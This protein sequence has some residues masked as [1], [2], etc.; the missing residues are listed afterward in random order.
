M[1]K[2]CFFII[3]VL[4]ANKMVGMNGIEYLQNHR[5]FDVVSVTP[6]NLSLKL[7]S[8]NLYI[9]N[10]D[11]KRKYQNPKA[12]PF[13]PF[14]RRSS[15]F[16]KNNELLVLTPDQVTTFSTRRHSLLYFTPVL[17]KTQEKGFQIRMEVHY[18]ETTTTTMY[19]ALSDTPKE[20]D[21]DDVE[22]IWKNG[23]L[24]TLEECQAIA[25]Q[26]KEE[27][28]AKKKF[29]ARF[30]KAVEEQYE[31]K[32]DRQAFEDKLNAMGS[33]EAILAYLDELE[34]QQHEPPMPNVLPPPC[35]T[36][37]RAWLWWLTLPVVA[38][39]WFVVYLGKKRK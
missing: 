34:S 18:L 1:K 10:D 5:W 6:T 19:F 26:E 12:P 35:R 8:D 3:A 15:E 21:E 16:I 7:I 31:T 27:Y 2:N 28:E 23:K 39:A 25:Q 37:S 36:A 30:T 24:R 13:A 11:L 20:V 17:F 14:D 33:R 9:D 29:N 4:L 38:G 32:D 22:M